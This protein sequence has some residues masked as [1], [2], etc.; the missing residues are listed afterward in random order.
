MLKKITKNSRRFIKRLYIRRGHI[1]WRNIWLTLLL[2]IS[3]AAWQADQI[4]QGRKEQQAQLTPTQRQ[5]Q[6][7]INRLAPVAKGTQR[8]YGVPASIT[9]AQAI[10]ESDWGQSKLATDYNNFFG[11]K[12]SSGMRKVT[13]P[14]KEVQDGQWVTVQ[15][16]FRWYTSWQESIWDHGKLLASG[17]QDNPRRYEAVI[18]A[19]NYQAAARALVTGG[20]ATDPDY[21][22]KLIRVIESYDL[23]RYDVR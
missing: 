4:N 23:D 16:P 1:F 19:A 22:N 14:T 13:L 2:V 21:A 6:A 10:L 17:T 11:V 18:Q 12:A 5:H 15:A 9:L 20:Y 8:Q 7:F 3:L